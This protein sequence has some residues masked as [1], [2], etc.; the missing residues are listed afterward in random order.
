MQY[1]K[2]SCLNPDAVYKKHYMLQSELI[3]MTYHPCRSYF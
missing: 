3:T 2:S 1:H